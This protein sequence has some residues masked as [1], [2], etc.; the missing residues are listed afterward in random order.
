MRNLFF[1]FS[2]IVLILLTIFSGCDPGKQTNEK[3][4][5]EKRTLQLNYAQQFAIEYTDTTKQV[6][7]LQPWSGSDKRF[8]YYLSGNKFSKNC[9]PLPVDSVVCFS[10]THLAMLNLLGVGDKIIA[11]PSRDD[12]YNIGIYDKNKILKKREMGSAVAQNLELLIHLA[13]DLVFESATG[14]AFDKFEKLEEVGLKTALFSAHTEPH[15]LGRAEWIKYMAVFFDLENKADSI[16][17]S[18]EQ[19]YNDIKKKVRTPKNRP[20]VFVGYPWKDAWVI[21]GGNSYMA[22]FIEDAGGSYIYKK[23]TASGNLHISLEEVSEKMSQCDIWL[24]PGTAVVRIEEIENGM[25]G[26]QLI[27]NM[28]IYNN[29]KRLNGSGKNDF[30]ES[31]IVNPDIILKDL[32]KIFHPEVFPGDDLYYFRNLRSH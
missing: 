32:V 13:P 3:K 20:I 12:V 23:D 9:I 7:I 14:S 22:R 6:T 21:P 1:V 17:Q 11:I 24:N 2:G 27:G 30:W 19:R 31:G 29:N 16:F 8:T 10:P 4:I 5:S 25:I 26:K 18:I 28:K 15:P